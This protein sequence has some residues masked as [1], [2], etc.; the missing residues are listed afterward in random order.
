M[1][2]SSPSVALLAGPQLL[3]MFFNWSLQGILTIQCYFYHLWFPRDPLW[4]KALVYGLLIWE[5]VQTGLITDVA[6]ENFVYNYGDH[7]A[8]VAFH[9]TW[10]SVTIM[11]AIASGVIQ[12]YFAWRILMVGRSKLLTTGIV[13]MSFAQMCVGI[14]GGVM[15]KVVDPAASEAS[16]VTPVISAWLAGA[17]FVDIVIAISMTILLVRAKSGIVQ[18]DDMINR[19]VRLVVETGTLT[20][21]V[22]IAD[23]VCFT[24]FSDTLL[25]EC[26]ALVLPK[27]YTNS[28]MASLNNRVF[29]RRITDGT[30]AVDSFPMNGAN[31]FTSTIDRD[32]FSAQ[33]R[34][35]DRLAERSAAQI[36]IQEVVL[37]HTDEPLQDG[38][39]SPPW[40]RRT[41]E[42]YSKT[43]VE[44]V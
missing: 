41:S 2:S 39:D 42:P 11:S 34:S 9:N 40:G 43:R 19:L 17:A 13:F 24:A 4:L 44:Y 5:W 8:L 35:A 10:F 22:A 28:L 1:A 21:A 26:P 25:H 37:T 12:G 32:R 16:A 23:L 18:S 14:A 27:L 29:M 6:F 30:I 38:K 31:T 36:H 3:G 33:L 15:L 20:A 7:A